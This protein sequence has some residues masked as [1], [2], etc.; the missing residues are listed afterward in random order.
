[1]QYHF[2]LHAILPVMQFSIYKLTLVW[3]L[4]KTT[5][6]FSSEIYI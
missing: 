1:M 3:Y 5:V 4:R 2:K 6:K